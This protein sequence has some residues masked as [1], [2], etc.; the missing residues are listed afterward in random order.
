MPRIL[1]HI[2]IDHISVSIQ[3]AHA[4]VVFAVR[5]PARVLLS[6][7]TEDQLSYSR[8]NS[9]ITFVSIAALIS[10]V[11]LASWQF[12]KYATFKHDVGFGRL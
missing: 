10:M 6:K 5:L 3:R 1:M 2:S 7:V 4:L 11:S 8:K 9:K 12:Y